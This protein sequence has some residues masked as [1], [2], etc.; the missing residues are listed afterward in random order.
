VASQAANAALATVK[1]KSMT[2]R[3]MIGEKKGGTGEAFFF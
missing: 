3:L 2:E 1:V